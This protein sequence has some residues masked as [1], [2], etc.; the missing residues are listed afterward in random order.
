MSNTRDL[1][2][3]SN[4]PKHISIIPDGNRTRAKKNW[5][6][7]FEWY[8]ES[9]EKAIEIIKYIFTKTPI[10]V[11]SWRGMS[12]EN[13]QKRPAAELDFL[14]GLYQSCGDK[15]NEF[16]EQ[17]KINFRW[18]WNMEWLPQD[19]LDYMKDM[20]DKFSFDTD[21]YIIFAIN[22]GG[23]DEIIRGIKSYIND[24]NDID[25]LTED[26][27]GD[28]MD[29]WSYDPVEL[30]IRTKWDTSSRIS[31]FMS[32]WIWYAELYFTS[33][34][35]QEVEEEDLTQ[36]LARYNDVYEYRNFGK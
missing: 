24:G 36:A 33:K 26:N 28:H 22:Y 17:E 30:V 35:F 8:L 18:I 31:W 14:F 4:F 5:V 20:V 32:R 7:V 9:V 19:F 12:T 29:L 16:L 13:R 10:K 21:R 11:F 15:L 27:L 34:L 2:N 23:R 6:S 3:I 1:S 25:N